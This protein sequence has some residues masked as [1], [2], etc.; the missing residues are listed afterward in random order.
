M[1][2]PSHANRNK[3]KVAKSGP[4]KPSPYR[5]FLEFGPLLIFFLVNMVYGIQLATAAL[6]LATLLVLP[7]SWW[8]EGRIPLLAVAGGAMVAFFGGLTILLADEFYI[9]IKPTLAS[10]A[11]AAVVFIGQAIG[12]NPIKFLL[13]ESLPQRL[14]PATYRQVTWCFI[15]M[16]VTIAIANE[17]A[18]RSLSTG[19]WVSFKVFGLTT[20]SLLYAIILAFILAKGQY[21]AQQ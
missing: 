19:A 11:F 12:K 18:W 16:M 10:L 21:T 9:K 2:P 1:P 3:G 17:I 20:I 15:A 4:G 13:R 14:P 5:F 8:L 6:V 7:L